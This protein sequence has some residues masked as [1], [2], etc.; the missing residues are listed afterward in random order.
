MSGIYTGALG[1]ISATTKF[2]TISNNIANSETDGYKTDEST[3][4]VWEETYAKIESKDR[5]EI[6]GGYNDQT[7][8]DN[9]KVNFEAGSTKLTDQEFDFAITDPTNS[10]NVSFFMVQKDGQTYLTRNGHFM[11]NVNGEVVN[12]NGGRLLGANGQPIVVPAQSHISISKK[13]EVRDSETNALYGTVDMR[14]VDES[15]LGLLEKKGSGYFQPITY[16]SVV[17]NFGSLENVLAQFDGN[18]T[19]QSV[20]GSKE[21]I[22]DM[23]DTGRVDIVSPFAGTVSAGVLEGSNVDLAK[24]MVDMMS[25]QRYFQANSKTFSVMDQIFAKESTEIGR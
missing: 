11:K 3:F 4:K 14:T 1:M 24:E 15:R 13:G 6:I 12:A 7:Y 23:I 9:T 21:N 22:Q 10:K 8:V 18:K 5:T 2:N 20:F 17:K 16:E 25:T 19:L